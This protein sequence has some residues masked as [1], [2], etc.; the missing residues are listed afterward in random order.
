MNVVWANSLALL[1]ELY[2]D[3][4]TPATIKD[5]IFNWVVKA[6]GTKL[7]KDYQENILCIVKH[8]HSKEHEARV[9]KKG[10]K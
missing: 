9:E 8:P 3:E 1:V 10:A 2:N 5:K 7:Y 6:W 4:N